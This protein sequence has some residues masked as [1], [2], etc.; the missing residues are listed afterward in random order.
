MH[1]RSQAD[2]LAYGYGRIAEA[3]RVVVPIRGCSAYLSPLTHAQTSRHRYINEGAYK[4]KMRKHTLVAWLPTFFSGRTSLPFY[5]S[6]LLATSFCLNPI[7][8]SIFAEQRKSVNPSNTTNITM[9][10]QIFQNFRIPHSYSQEN[11]DAENTIT[12][13]QVNL[14]LSPEQHRLEGEISTKSVF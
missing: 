2:L 4:P 9:E 13:Q 3:S 7:D 14:R 8:S 1:L 6:F 11:H 10:D 12:G 5:Q